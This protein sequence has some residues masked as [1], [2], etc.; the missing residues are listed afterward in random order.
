MP[1]SSHGRS[2][3]LSSPPG[4]RATTGAP[5]VPRWVPGGE[6]S[7]GDLPWM[8]L[9]IHSARL[10]IGTRDLQLDEALGLNCTWYAD[11]LLTLTEA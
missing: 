1:S 11:I 2:P 7:L 10:D 8:L 9:G 5:L 4:T 3:R 6:E